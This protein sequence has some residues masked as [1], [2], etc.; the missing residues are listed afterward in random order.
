MPRG[1]RL[2]VSDQKRDS[3]QPYRE[4]RGGPGELEWLRWTLPTHCAAF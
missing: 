1:E 2:I 3:R 4:L